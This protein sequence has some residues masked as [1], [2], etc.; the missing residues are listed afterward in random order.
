MPT[1]REQLRR[2]V[3]EREPPSRSIAWDA[4]MEALGQLEEEARRGRG[5]VLEEEDVGVLA[6]L[7]ARRG[8]VPVRDSAPVPHC[9]PPEELV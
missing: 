5:G 7:V 8:Q 9:M 3:A 2:M 6:A 4:L 1:A